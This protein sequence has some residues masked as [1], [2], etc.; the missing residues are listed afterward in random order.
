MNRIQSHVA[1]GALRAI[2]P[3]GKSGLDPISAP[4]RGAAY[5]PLATA[6]TNELRDAI[7]DGRLRPGAPIRQE[8]I[9]RQYGT[10][11]IP[12]RE[13]LRQLE[14]EGLVTIRPRSGARVATVDFEECLEIYKIR[15][16]LEPLAFGES[17]GRLTRGQLATVRRLA[18]ETEAVAA[19]HSAWLDADRRFHLACY[20][21]VPTPRLLS[22]IV[23]FWNT[24]QQYRRLLVST[25]R[26][27]DFEIYH[28]E[29]WLMTEALR[30]GSVR[31]GEELVRT[32][33]ERSRMRL[34]EHRKLFDR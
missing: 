29:H 2:R 19:D 1:S 22:M 15:E 4:A 6:V 7:L 12:V 20:V 32:H 30:G 28:R 31:A 26:P 10:S 21:G 5:Q 16:R 11:R 25:L 17:V 24:T 18:E 27:V 34:S 14:A 33:I 8:A 23:G 9:A 3:G 13:A